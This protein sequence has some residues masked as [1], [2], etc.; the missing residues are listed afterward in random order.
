M[1]RH[2]VVVGG[3]ISGLAAAWT[4]SQG[5]DAPS[6]TVLEGSRQLGGK[7]RT[8]PVGSVSVDLG[9]E[10]FL[11]RRPEAVRLVRAA[12]LGEDL[13][14]P[15][16]SAANL[17]VRGR[18]TGMP[19][20]TM[21][22]VPRSASV[23]AG[24]LE[25]QELAVVAGEPGRPRRPLTEDV[26]VGQYVA[27]RVG[28]PVVDRLVEPL[29]GGVY[30]GHADALS[31]QVS[32]PALWRVAAAGGSL[33]EGVAALVPAPG[34]EPVTG[35][36]GG[37][38]GGV[39]RLPGA[40]AER[41]AE[42]GVRL[43][44]GLPVTALQRAPHG[45][46]VVLGSAGDGSREQLA[47]DAVLL[48]VPAPATARLLAGIDH[49]GAAA[50]AAELG[51]VQLASV[52]VVALEVP[53][54][55]VAKLPG[56]GLLVP[57]VEGAAV[58]LSAKAFTFSSAK[59]A[60]VGEQAGS[61]PDPLRVVRASFG[62]AGET[63]TLQ[64]DD[65]ELAALAARDL[66]AVAGREVVPVA[67]RVVRWGGG[68]PQPAVGHL[69]LVARARAGVAR[70]PG[71]ALAGAVMDGVGIPACIAAADRA[72]QEL[73]ALLSRT[74]PAVAAAQGGEGQ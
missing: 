68:L 24:V 67:H 25:E 27:C 40:L 33:L 46:R 21:M 30:A 59:W 7:L 51:R 48:A 73:L 49:P 20:G 38:R 5:P 37:V 55:M 53:A 8:G 3:G 43:R 39:G 23:L 9:A 2:V 10:S 72:A 4:L 63:A 65:E 66:S 31:L 42:R 19:R 26:S 35:V 74:G 34:P 71:L 15:A 64:R 12:G 29:L 13:V 56:S 61:G 22:G 36:F 60:W 58:G 45:W 44:T 70:L 14:E 16:S 6:V 1:S 18:L 41:L 32:V 47:A 62:R 54:S 11:A 50:A 17:L 52:A 28:R 69:E 57:P